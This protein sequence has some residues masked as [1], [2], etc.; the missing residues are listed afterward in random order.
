[1][2]IHT[3]EDKLEQSTVELDILKLMLST[4]EYSMQSPEWKRYEVVLKEKTD[5][6]LEYKRRTTPQYETAA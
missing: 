4:G 6:F 1:M 3:L 5:L 2:D